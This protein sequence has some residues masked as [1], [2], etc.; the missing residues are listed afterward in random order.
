MRDA[1]TTATFTVPGIKGAAKVEVLGE[2]RSLLCVD[3]KF[4]DSFKGYEVHLY[5]ITP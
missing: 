3:G 4:Q 1:E 2:D 5:K